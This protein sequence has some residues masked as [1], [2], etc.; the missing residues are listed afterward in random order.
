MEAAGTTLRFI[1]SFH[2]S[3]LGELTELNSKT[4][5]EYLKEA[6]IDNKVKFVIFNGKNVEIT[7]KDINDKK[8]SY[9]KGIKFGTKTIFVRE[10]KIDNKVKFVNFNGKNVEITFKDINDKKISLEKGIK[11]G[12]KTIFEYGVS[13]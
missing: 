9:E 1:V 3:Q 8:I 12:T 6:K 2:G 7:F 5:A 13:P 11:F 10:A 4:V